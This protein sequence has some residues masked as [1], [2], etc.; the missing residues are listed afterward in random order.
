MNRIYLAWFKLPFGKTNFGDELSPFIVKKLTSAKIVFMP[1]KEDSVKKMLL[2]F[3][4]LLY[5]RRVTVRGFFD[6]MRYYID[7]KHSVIYAIGSIIK[8]NNYKKSI[9]WGSGIISKD[10]HINYSVFHA[11]RGVHTQ[12]RILELG[13]NAPQVLGDPAVLLPL[14]YEVKFSKKKYTLGIIPHIAHQEE[15]LSKKYDKKIKVIDLT[16]PI[17]K[18]IL[19]INSCEKTM[20]SSLHGII[21]SHAYGIPSLWVN[22]S[23]TKL[24]GDNIK[25]A[26]YFSSVNIEEYLPLKNNMELRNI[27]IE[28]LFKNHRNRSLPPKG[29]ISKLQNELLKCAPFE[30]LEKYKKKIS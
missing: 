14:V 9:I 17:E 8:T 30:I 10:E 24:A 2:L 16:D 3:T 29:V 4:K 5:T 28:N 6:I 20:C 19:D 12:K 13:Y 7:G 18:V 22:L 1:Y 26:D 25:Y 11:V 21:V 15:Y 23:D 27:C